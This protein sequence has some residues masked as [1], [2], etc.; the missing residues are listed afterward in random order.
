[1]FEAASGGGVC[2]AKKGLADA[3]L[4]DVEDLAFCGGD[5]F[6]SSQSRHGLISA[7]RLTNPQSMAAGK[8]IVKQKIWVSLM[9]RLAVPVG[10]PSS[11]KCG[12]PCWGAFT[13]TR[14]GAC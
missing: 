10:E 2:S 11:T 12:C 9:K 3:E 4:G 14:H 7:G 1:M 8:R 13:W 6:F 5:G